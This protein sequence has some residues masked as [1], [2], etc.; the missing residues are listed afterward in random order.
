MKYTLGT[1][2]QYAF[3]PAFVVILMCEDVLQ[4]CRNLANKFSKRH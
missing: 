4:G 2:L 3:L 1:Y